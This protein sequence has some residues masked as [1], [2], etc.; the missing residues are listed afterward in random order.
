VT[1]SDRTG[2][3]GVEP[4]DT[5]WAAELAGEAVRY[6]ARYYPECAASEVLTDHEEAAHEA[7]MDADEEG[8]RAALRA[9]CRAGR[10]GAAD[11]KGRGVNLSPQETIVITTALI[12]AAGNGYL[13]V[14]AVHDG[15]RGTDRAASVA[16][17]VFSLV[18]AMFF[19]RAL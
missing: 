14:A 17:F 8:Y 5:E 6:L 9:Y 2:A 15:Q 16:F 3:V 10:D 18:A 4:W 11:T 1:A 13:V 19:L 12:A 7:A